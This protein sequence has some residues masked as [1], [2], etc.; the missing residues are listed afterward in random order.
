MSV[1]VFLSDWWFLPLVI[2]LFK[3][4]KKQCY[5]TINNFS[6]GFVVPICYVINTFIGAK[7]HVNKMTLFKHSYLHL[8]FV[9]LSM[10]SC[11]GAYLLCYFSV[12]LHRNT[13]LGIIF[14]NVQLRTKIWR[15]KCAAHGAQPFV[16]QS[17]CPL[18]PSKFAR[19][20][21]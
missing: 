10:L 3:G 6:N 18:L 17:L 7:C 15:W 21:M 11:S 2:C 4:N 19:V 8:N 5:I 14:L 13:S 1:P 12:S 9:L 16:F 20:E